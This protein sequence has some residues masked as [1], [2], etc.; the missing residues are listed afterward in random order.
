MKTLQT[1]VFLP[2]DYNPPKYNH[3]SQDGFGGTDHVVPSWESSANIFLSNLSTSYDAMIKSFNEPINSTLYFSVNGTAPDMSFLRD[4]FT[5]TIETLHF[6]D[7]MSQYGVQFEPLYM[8]DTVTFVAWFSPL[9]SL[10]S[11]IILFDIIWRILQSLRY[12]YK[13]WKGSIIKIEPADLRVSSQCTGNKITRWMVPIQ[14]IITWIS[15]LSF[16]I[17]LLLLG[18]GILLWT[19]SGNYFLSN[20]VSSY[21]VSYIPMYESYKS[22]CVHPQKFPHDSKLINGTF[23]SR[24]MRSVAFNYASGLG[25]KKILSNLNDYQTMASGVC[26]DTTKTTSNRMNLITRDLESILRSNKV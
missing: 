25:K 18:I 16:Y 5:S 1:D 19:F 9:L 6:K 15:Q 4:L 20:F 22:V 17:V 12:L 2:K 14:T 10:S 8:P 13:H 26:A 21:L 24:N 7:I 11:Q 23:L 3:T